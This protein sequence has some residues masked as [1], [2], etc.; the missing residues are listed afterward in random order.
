MTT[1]QERVYVKKNGSHVE[2]DRGI[3]WGYGF[4]Y[5]TNPTGTYTIQMDK[6]GN[7]LDLKEEDFERIKDEV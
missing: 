2:T 1:K 7:A 5:G 4:I 6:W 3:N